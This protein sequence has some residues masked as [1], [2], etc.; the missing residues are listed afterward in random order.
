MT[1]ARSLPAAPYWESAL[2]DELGSWRAND[3]WFPDHVDPSMI[4]P[5]LL[6][7][8]KFVFDMQYN[9]DGSFHKFKI[10]L[11]VRG[12]RWTDVYGM[13]T[14]AST[15]KPESVRL[16]LSIAAAEDMLIE[17]VDVKTAFLYPPLKPDE[18]IYMRRPKGLSDSDMPPVVRLKKCVYGLPQASAYFRAHSDATLRA[19]G[20]MPTPEDDCVYTYDA[21]DGARVFICAHVDDF[22]LISKS[23]TAID[24]VKAHL[25]LTYSLKVNA[26][27]SYYLGMLI[28]RDRSERWITLSQPRYIAELA[29][30]FNIEMNAPTAWPTTPLAYDP[31][32]RPPS[33]D[34][35]LPPAG[36]T[37]YQSRVG[38]LLYLAI[39]TRPDILYAMSMLSRKNKAPTHHDLSYVNRVLLYVIGTRDLALKF[40]STEGVKL[41]ATVDASY[42]C[43]PDFKSHSG[44]TL[45][46]GRLS[47]TFHAL[48]KKQTV[49]ADSS[50]VAE[51]IATHTVAKEIMWT[52]GLLFSLGFRQ[53]EPT[54]L[55][56]DNM[57]TIAMI[58]NPTNGN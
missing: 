35:P 53:P 19:F 13:S 31:H 22:G 58:H 5:S 10:R 37:D 21:P 24:T 40:H 16:I 54:I 18:I 1:H 9:P 45:H 44:C 12:D 2:H 34:I 47:G 46:I 48:S 25:A 38:S 36:I 6:M 26:D 28:S 32:R 15:V 43:H 49:T 29:D 7:P 57:S 14:Y 33:K 55:Y 27:M 30:R 50:T 4:D 17:S 3:T 52:R 23:Q 41:Y 51:F 11:V 56:E 39:N 8:S 20:A 42:A